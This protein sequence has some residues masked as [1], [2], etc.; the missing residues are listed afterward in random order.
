MLT[1]NTCGIINTA[2][3]WFKRN[4]VLVECQAQTLPLQLAK[5]TVNT[6]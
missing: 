6:K 1:I 4:T 2:Y 3:A 5:Q